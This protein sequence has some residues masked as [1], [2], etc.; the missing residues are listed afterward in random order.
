MLMK[1]FYRIISAT[2]YMSAGYILIY[3]AFKSSFLKFYG[4]GLEHCPDFFAPKAVE[5]VGIVFS[6]AFV[7]VLILTV[8]KIH[9]ERQNHWKTNLILGVPLWFSQPTIE[10]FI[11]EFSKNVPC[12]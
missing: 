4:Y 8:L 7:I 2:Q 1:T 11:N 10:F 12:R 9:Y 3:I 6:V 5:I